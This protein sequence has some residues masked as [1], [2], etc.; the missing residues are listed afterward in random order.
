MVL[1]YKY[2]GNMSVAGM[3]AIWKIVIWPY[4]ILGICSITVYIV[5]LY[6]QTAF[7]DRKSVLQIVLEIKNSEIRNG[8][9]QTIIAKIYWN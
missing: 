6:I 4:K 5:L 1:Q 2:G 7:G 9:I 8:V 3:S